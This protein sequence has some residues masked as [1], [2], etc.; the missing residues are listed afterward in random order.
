MSAT[1]MQK[2]KVVSRKEWIAARKELLAKEKKLTREREALA[3]E[4]RNL[5]WV[6]VEEEYVFDT[7]KGKKKLADLFEGR[8]QLIV[9]H[10]ML[11]PGWE[12]GCPGCSAIADHIDGSVTHLANRDVTLLAVSRAPL[13]EI[14]A[15]Q[16]RMG[17]KFKWVSS[18]GSEFNKDYHV[19]T[20][21]EELERGVETF[22]NFETKKAASEERPGAS[23]FYKNEKG[24]VF[25]TYS[26]YARGLEQL[27]GFYDYLDMTAKG[28]DEDATA[29]NKATWLRH[30]D[31]YEQ[32]YYAE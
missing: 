1:G 27:M 31:K 15:F 23:V 22:Y 3:G 17:W 29:K 14:K 13:A 24:E 6:K 12:A 16:K 21:K 26:A 28:R 5:P 19:S 20:T 4:R 18:F 10:F 9:Y 25:H 11:G 7:P 32:S 30:H 2:A 8:S